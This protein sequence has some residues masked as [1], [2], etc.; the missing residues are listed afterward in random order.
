MTIGI[1][2]AMEEEVRG[3]RKKMTDKIKT[4]RAGMIFCC[5]KLS[6]RDVVVV[7]S[8]VGKVNAAVCTQILIDEYKADYI[9]NTGIAGALDKRLDIGDIV[10]SEDAIYHDVDATVFGYQYGEVPRLKVVAF[11]ADKKLMSAALSSCKNVG[12]DVSVYKGRITSGDRFVSSMSDKNNIIKNV[13]GM[14][15]EMEGAAI[16]QVSYINKVPYVI[17]RAIS[18]RADGKAAKESVAFTPKAVRHCM[19]IVLDMVNSL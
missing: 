1:I 9:I 19:D 5:G 7:R 15:A 4:K 16:A 2:G 10:I 3:L 14:C 11:P 18:D 13:G 12:L 17:V 8:G 6:D